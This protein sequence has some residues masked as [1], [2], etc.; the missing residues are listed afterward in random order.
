MA[1]HNLELMRRSE[2]RTIE[3][4][5]GRV[6]SDSGRSGRPPSGLR[7]GC[8]EDRM[9]AWHRHARTQRHGGPCGSLSNEGLA[10]R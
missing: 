6:V 9:P 4:L 5:H 8:A 3:M 2:Y 10:R 1:T 7:H